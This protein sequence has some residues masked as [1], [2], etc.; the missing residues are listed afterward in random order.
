MTNYKDLDVWNKSITLVEKVYVITKIFPEEEKFALTN[1]VRR[2]VISIPSNIAEGWG[3]KSTKD[4]IRFLHIALGSLYE[5]ETQLIIS[6]KINYIKDEDLQ[7][8]V[9]II[10]DL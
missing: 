7:M 3:R 8:I 2:S 9:L 6:E 5:L 1:Q 4:Y 10:K